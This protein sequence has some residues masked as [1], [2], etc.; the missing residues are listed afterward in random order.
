MENEEWNFTKGWKA[1]ERGKARW[2]KGEWRVVGEGEREKGEEWN[3]ECEREKDEGDREKGWRGRQ[4]GKYWEWV[5]EGDGRCSSD[6]RKIG[7]ES[8]TRLL[9]LL[10]LI[11]YNTWVAE[12]YQAS[13]SMDAYRKLDAKHGKY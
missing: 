2:R 8:V 11:V 13:K 1:E 3:K 6:F 7:E 4:E 5:E 9:L 12:H 10:L